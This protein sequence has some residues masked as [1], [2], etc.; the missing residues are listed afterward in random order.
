VPVYV[1]YLTV[2]PQ[3]GEKTLVADVYGWDSDAR[4]QTASIQAAAGS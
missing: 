4:L 2:Q 3:I 1:T